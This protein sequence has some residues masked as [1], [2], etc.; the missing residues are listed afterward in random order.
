[1]KDLMELVGLEI[2]GTHYKEFDYCNDE[3]DVREVL[4][5]LHRSREIEFLNEKGIG[6]Y[7][8]KEAKAIRGSIEEN[9]L[10]VEGRY[11]VEVGNVRNHEDIDVYV[12]VDL[13]GYMPEEDEWSEMSYLEVGWD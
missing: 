9:H 5:R 6:T 7:D 10:V 11:H 13:Y 1:M 12:E 2:Y 8:W 3:S 4:D